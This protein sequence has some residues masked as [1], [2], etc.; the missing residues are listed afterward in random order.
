[1]L[2]DFVT[3][4]ARFGSPYQIDKA[5]RDGRLFKMDVGVY[6]DDGTESEIEV[7]LKKYPR[8]IVSFDSA[9][10]YYDMTDYIPDRYTLTIGNHARR[11]QDE[12]IKNFFVPEEVLEVGVTTFDYDGAKIRIYDKE[13]LLIDTARMKGRLPSDL[14]KEVVNGYRACR[15]SLDA[16]KFPLYLE[17][18]PHRDR[19]M[20][21]IDEEVY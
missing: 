17:N 12:R 14:Y 9:Y 8:A 10:F 2:L 4:K 1:M 7:V 13:R 18:F 16:A 20:R 11:I 6:S 15:D 21:I 19:I 3:C 5:I